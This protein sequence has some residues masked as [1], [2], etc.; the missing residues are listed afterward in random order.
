MNRTLI[1]TEEEFKIG[2]VGYEEDIFE[3]LQE[4]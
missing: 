1:Q 4:K 3:I 2:E